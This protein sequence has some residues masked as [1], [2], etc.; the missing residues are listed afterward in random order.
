MLR[1]WLK[2][3]LLFGFLLLLTAFAGCAA[4]GPSVPSGG[5][6]T[7]ETSVEN[8]TDEKPDE[9]CL[10]SDGVSR[11]SIVYQSG[12][13]K[14]L[15]DSA[16][17]FFNFYK[18][19]LEEQPSY[20]SDTRSPMASGAEILIGNTNR[21]ATA[22]VQASLPSRSWRVCIVGES[23][24]ICATEEWMIPNALAAFKEAISFAK[25]NT[26]ATISKDLNLTKTYDEYTRDRW[27]LSF[28]TF[29]GGVLADNF[30]YQNYGYLSAGYPIVNNYMLV[31]ASDT[32]ENEMRTY[33]QKLESHGYTVDLVCD[34]GAILSWRVSRETERMYM[35]L[36]VK[37]G[38]ARFALD[39]NE[40]VLPS[41]FSYTY[42]EQ[43]G[44]R[45]VLYLY[46]LV[47]DQKG[48][49]I[50][51]TFPNGSVN[52]STLNCGQLQIVKLADN[53]VIVIDGAGYQQMSTEAAV[54][55][56]RFLH[57]ITNTPQGEKVR[58]ANWLITHHHGDHSSGMIRFLNA[59]HEQYELERLCYNFSFTAGSSFSQFIALL[60]DWYPTAQYYRPHTGESVTLAGTRLDFL[61]TC[62]DMIKATTGK[63]GSTDD[64]DA[65]MVVRFTFDGRSFLLTGDINR[66]AQ[67]VILKNYSADQLRADILQVAH[68]CW[69]DV[70]DL[71]AAVRPSISLFTQSEGAA[72][73]RKP[74][75][76]NKVIACTEGGAK[77]I[78]FAGNPD[79]GTVGISVVDGKVTVVDQR[80]VVG[81]EYDGK[82]GIFTPFE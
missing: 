14:N 71:Y 39:Q 44:D 29:D 9:I 23:I 12:A 73:A 49:N 25:D 13:G 65:S 64:N 81:T 8:V 28:P 33:V 72:R 42:A 18:D 15:T 30:Y 3:V 79:N 61:Y 68:H 70:T 50:G 31:L 22:E 48:Y 46:G 40:T 75:I 34:N 35:Y 77:N 69:N 32:D 74:Y 43:S 82:W 52:Q 53:S 60:R 59:Y 2:C 41:E 80:A 62:E 7:D 56:N 21:A 51:E 47:M 11:Y 10:I 4:E 36:S 5:V 54:E 26:T 17:S 76:V 67:T 58:I 63:F 27:N 45:A 24:V 20:K 37:Q 78:F 19:S 55:L 57:E 66:N 16:K 38:E 1:T 6:L